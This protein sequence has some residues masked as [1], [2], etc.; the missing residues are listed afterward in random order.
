MTHSSPMPL[1]VALDMAKRLRHELIRHMTP[2]Q[3]RD[4][5]R[6]E[7]LLAE[8]NKNH[9]AALLKAKQESATKAAVQPATHTRKSFWGR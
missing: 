4:F 8:A 9:Q 1:A 2:E 3:Q 5:M 6:L 7:N